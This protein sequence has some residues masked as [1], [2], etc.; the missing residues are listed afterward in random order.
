MAVLL[1]ACTTSQ[2]GRTGAA[3]TTDELLA[4]TALGFADSPDVAVAPAEVLALSPE[5][6][7]FID[8]HVDRSGGAALKLHQLA[9]SIIDEKTF[10]VTYDDR[11]RTAAETFRARRGNCLSFSTM[12]VAMAR[13]VGLDVQYQEVEIP[14]DWTLDNDTYVLNQHVNVYVNLE[15]AAP[16]V[17]DFNIAD[18]KSS[19]EMERIP[20][21]R[22]LAHHYNNVGVERM[23]AGD[24]GSA[25]AHFRRALEE[26]DRAFSPAWV[27][28][29]T[30]YLRGGRTAE[31]EAAYLQALAAD[32][33][34]LV[35]M[36]S[37]ARLYDRLGERERAAACRKRVVHHRNRNPYYRYELARRA[38][39]AHDYRAAIGH[40][41]YAARKRPKEDQ[42]CFLLGACYL[43]GGDERQAR[44]WFDRAE[45]LAATDAQKRRYS[46]KIDTVLRR[47]DPGRP[48]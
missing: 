22:A 26:S 41:K 21:T 9:S 47:P 10:G 39:L 43:Q 37:L 36:S 24:A 27:N 11:T 15:P 31:A 7:A 19:Y 2:A 13:D 28:L 4:G 20:D 18:F 25:L 23:Q 5:M 30:L 35:A 16:K 14:P 6:R 38:Y 8:A 48:E 3:V 44:R 45:E 33:S 1:C 46:S 12:F 29:G 32:S 34:D 42:F 40:L 17:V